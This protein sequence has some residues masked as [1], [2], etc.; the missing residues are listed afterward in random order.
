MNVVLNLR[1]IMALAL[2][3]ALFQQVATQQSSGVKQINAGLESKVAMFE[4]KLTLSFETDIK[5]RPACC[6]LCGPPESLECG[7]PG[8]TPGCCR[9]RTCLDNVT[10]PPTPPGPGCENIGVFVVPEKGK[11]LIVEKA[12]IEFYSARTGL[13]VFSVW[14][15]RIGCGRDLKPT[16]TSTGCMLTMNRSAAAEARKYC[17]NQHY[18]RVWLNG[19]N[20]PRVAYLVDAR[21]GKPVR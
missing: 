2:S 13:V 3:C 4:D 14:A 19:T 7:P 17:D 5:S 9:T 10:C 12:A 21:A 15:D 11:N 1:L 18:I 6:P 16:N 8:R 20:V